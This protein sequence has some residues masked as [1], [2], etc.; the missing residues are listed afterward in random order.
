MRDD[1]GT[2]LR[3]GMVRGLTR[4]CY[5]RPQKGRKEGGSAG[6]RRVDRGWWDFDVVVVFANMQLLV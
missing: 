5:C 2:E 1:S 6:C 3:S 4:W